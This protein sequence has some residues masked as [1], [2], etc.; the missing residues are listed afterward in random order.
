MQL[1][2]DAMSDEINRNGEVRLLCDRLEFARDTTPSSTWHGCGNRML[3]HRF[4]TCDESTAIGGHVSD[5]DGD[6]AIRAPTVE[7]NAHV[8]GDK[9]AV[10]YDARTRNPVHQ[11]LIHTDTGRRRKRRTRLRSTSV[12]DKEGLTTT[13][14][15]RT[16]CGLV[17]LRCG[18]ARLASKSSHL[19]DRR[20]EGSS[21]LN[22]HHIRFRAK[23]D[24]R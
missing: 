13:R 4:S 21:A 12:S 8:D 23:L 14:E 3:Q 2:T 18:D 20:N 6:R 19:E 15:N 22:P 17:D 9:I 5:A 1:P 7:P 11:L 10:L 24:A 16:V